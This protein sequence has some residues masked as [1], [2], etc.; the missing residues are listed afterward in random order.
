MYKYLLLLFL[1]APLAKAL[2]GA[3]TYCIVFWKGETNS[4]IMLWRIFEFTFGDKKFSKS[5]NVTR[6]PAQSIPP[7]LA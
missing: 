6:R 1:T 3:L 7:N 2:A 5:S 4:R